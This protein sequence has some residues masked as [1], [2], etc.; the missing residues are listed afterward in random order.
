V[1][2]FKTLSGRPGLILAGTL[3][4]ALLTSGC[5]LLGRSP[6][7]EL[8]SQPLAEPAV[9][10]A[11]PEP[12]A[13][14][15]PLPSADALLSS[16]VIGREDPLAPQVP[17]PRGARSSS[18]SPGTLDAPTRTDQATRASRGGSPADPQ[19]GGSAARP[20]AVARLELPEDFR[21]S[22]VL[23]AGSTPQAFVQVGDQSGPVCPGPDGSCPASGLPSVL[24]K[25]WGVAAID[26]DR[27]RLTLRQGSRTVTTQL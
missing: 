12:L 13:G 23:R 14:L 2:W 7:P 9:A 5:G 26:V 15:T 24:P 20:A 18:Q 11:A 8:P 10:E 16:V 22:G 21:F 17:V 6:L 1:I 19:G 27:G 3:T 4:G 25:G